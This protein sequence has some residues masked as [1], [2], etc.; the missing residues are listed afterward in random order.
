[1]CPLDG[2]VLPADRDGFLVTMDCFD[3]PD[4]D[5]FPKNKAPFHHDDFLNDWD[6]REVAL[7]PHLGHLVD[8]T[9]DW[10]MLDDDIDPCHRLIHEV[11]VADS[12]NRN[13]DR[14]GFDRAPNYFELFGVQS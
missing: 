3:A 5:L 11:V 10:N 9:A 8:H 14:P 13:A 1:M 2:D 4:V 6:D 12:R 7:L